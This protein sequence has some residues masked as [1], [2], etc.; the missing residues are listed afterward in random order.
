M[1]QT[2]KRG[3]PFETECVSVQ[4]EGQ[5]EWG[6]LCSDVL[7]LFQG[8]VDYSV[9]VWLISPRVQQHDSWK[10]KYVRDILSKQPDGSLVDFHWFGHNI[11]MLYY[12]NKE[13]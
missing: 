12:A 4:E 6:A 7:T 13:K 3:K 9:K 11:N 5:C 2:P 8:G 1:T 10:Q